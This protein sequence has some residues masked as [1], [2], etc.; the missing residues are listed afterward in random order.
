M[1]RAEWTVGHR[2]LCSTVM[3]KAG[4]SH[5]SYSRTSALQ[6][7]YYWENSLFLDWLQRK[8]E[9]KYVY[10]CFYKLAECL[11][12]QQTADAD[13]HGVLLCAKKINTLCLTDSEAGT[14]LL[15]ELSNWFTVTNGWYWLLQIWVIN[16]VNNFLL[17]ILYRVMEGLR[18]T[19]SSTR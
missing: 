18:I 5:H 10:N 3:K 19:K 2:V 4:L 13:K 8:S 7:W 15:N 11:S 1:E 9:I 6:W 16:I 17:L 14:P 12:T